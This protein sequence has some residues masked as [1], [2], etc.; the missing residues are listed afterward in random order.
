MPAPHYAVFPDIYPHDQH[1]PNIYPGDY[2]MWCDTAGEAVAVMNEM[3]Q[4]TGVG[5]FIMERTITAYPPEPIPMHVY[6]GVTP[7]VD[8]PVSLGPERG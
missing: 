1:N 8:F 7:G 3:T 4:E 5:H 6:N 2:P